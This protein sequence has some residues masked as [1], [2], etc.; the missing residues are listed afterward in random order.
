MDTQEPHVHR[1]KVVDDDR[2]VILPGG[3]MTV[4]QAAAYLG[5]TYQTFRRMRYDAHSPPYHQMP[6]K[7][8]GRIYYLKRE[9][10]AWLKQG[11]IKHTRPQKEE[12]HAHD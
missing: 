5:Y 2:M 6:G 8:R 3:R 1:T 11:D 10:D 7:T 12:N 4:R 9:L